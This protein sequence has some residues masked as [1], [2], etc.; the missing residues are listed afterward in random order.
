MNQQKQTLDSSS[1]KQKHPS[2]ETSSATVTKHYSFNNPQMCIDQQPPTQSNPTTLTMDRFHNNVYCSLPQKKPLVFFLLPVL[3]RCSTYVHAVQLL[4][5]S[6]WSFEHMDR[7]GIGM[8]KG[9]FL[10]PLRFHLNY[11]SNHNCEC[12]LGSAF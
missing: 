4:C 1:S 9:I 12:I 2:T 6:P 8:V 7:F 3:L 10:S 11:T 5:F